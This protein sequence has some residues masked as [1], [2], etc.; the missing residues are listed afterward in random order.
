MRISANQRQDWI[1][2]EAA[3]E[4]LVK[5]LRASASASCANRTRPADDRRAWDDFFNLF[6]PKLYEL[7]VRCGAGQT[8]LDEI[9]EDVRC[10]IFI[11]L[12][13]FIWQ[14]SQEFHGWLFLI[15]R[16]QVCGRRCAKHRHPVQDLSC[17]LATRR[18]PLDP[19]ESPAR[20]WERKRL[21]EFVRCVLQHVRAEESELNFVLF[22]RHHIEQMEV[23]QVAAAVGLTPKKAEAHLHRTLL[24]FAALCKQHGAESFAT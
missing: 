23:A 15:V 11:R 1:L 4:R 24:K 3:E 12:P 2:N 7:A 6:D 20:V 8:E 22:Y 9:V 17:L 5:A 18:E 19:G 16:G 10:A 21:C 14:G 13:G